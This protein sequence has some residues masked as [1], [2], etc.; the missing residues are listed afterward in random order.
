[1]LPL[2]NFEYYF[3]NQVD[4]MDTKVGDFDRWSD[5]RFASA[6]LKGLGRLIRRFLCITLVP[7]VSS[8]QQSTN[9][10][11]KSCSNPDEQLVSTIGTDVR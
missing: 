10:S 1:V 3:V 6:T 9:K 11:P 4:K 2:A 8:P 5:A 7:F